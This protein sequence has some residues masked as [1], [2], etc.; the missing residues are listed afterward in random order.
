MKKVIN[1]I[2]C[3]TIGVFVIT[4]MLSTQAIAEER[5]RP[6]G[7]PFLRLQQQIDVLNKCMQPV[8][9]RLFPSEDSGIRLP[10]ELSGQTPEERLNHYINN[11]REPIEALYPSDSLRHALRRAADTG[12]D[13]RNFLANTKDLIEY[14]KQ[15]DKFIQDSPDELYELRLA[16][17]LLR[18]TD[19]HQPLFV[20][21]RQWQHAEGLTTLQDISNVAPQRWREFVA[22][23][24]A[25]QDPELFVRSVARTFDALLFGGCKLN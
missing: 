13:I 24:S 12:L 7:R 23:S 2:I 4:T 8:L 20:R 19:Y 16:L 10:D 3:M 18:L 15:I 9:V 14:W 25:D 6:S 1:S 17:F 22:E 5:H 11:L 21:L